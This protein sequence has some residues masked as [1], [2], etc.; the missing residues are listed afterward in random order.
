MEHLE[1]TEEARWMMEEASKE[2]DLEQIGIQLDARHEQSQAECHLE[3]AV[4][5]PDYMHLET[6]GFETNENN[7]RGSDIFK[8]IIIPDRNELRKQNPESG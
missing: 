4:P 6:D 3:G 8:K 2:V 1:S 5:H 7:I